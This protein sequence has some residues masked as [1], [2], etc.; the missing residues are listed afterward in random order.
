M[1]VRSEGVLGVG[2]L[3]IITGLGF[4]CFGLCCGLCLSLLD[5]AVGVP[6][7]YTHF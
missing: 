5:W 4:L 7:V 3:G 6:R 2:W 1:V